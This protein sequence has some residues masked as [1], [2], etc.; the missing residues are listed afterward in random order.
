MK[1]FLYL[2]YPFSLLYQFLFYLDKTFKKK[3]KFDDSFVISVGNLTT[4]GTGKTPLTIYLSNLLSGIFQDKEIIILSRGYRGT[5]TNEGMIVELNSSPI[6]TGDEPLL[7][8]TKIPTVQVIIGKKRYNSFYKFY[9]SLKSISKF[10]LSLKDINARFSPRYRSKFRERF[11]IPIL[12]KKEIKKDKLNKI[13]ILDDGFQH[14]AIL[15]NLDLLLIDSDNAIGN[16]FTIPIG[17]LRESISAVKRVKYIFFTRYSKENS[18]NVEIIKM[19]FLKINPDLKFFHLTYKLE[20]IQNHKEKLLL[21]SL[22]QKKITLFSALGN[23]FSFETS[24]EDLKPFKL[25]KKRFPDHFSYTEETIL[26]LEKNLEKDEILICT[27][28]D[29]IKIK[30]LNL[31]EETL[32]KI[33]FLPI[34]VFINKQS[35]LKSDIEKIINDFFKK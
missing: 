17:N 2:L 22:N 21:S 16:G 3:N 10:A 8:K 9:P 35:E 7:I 20:F 4:G 29:Y 15:R 32:S 31:S 1:F 27:E 6:E 19:K 24:I 34:E 25:T 23:P 30:S 14:H 18:Y 13:I 11:F 12:E 33:Y 26:S 28:K 5:K